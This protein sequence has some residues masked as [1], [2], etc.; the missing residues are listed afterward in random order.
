MPPALAQV[1]SAVP[2]E[3]QT[4][5]PSDSLPNPIGD[6]AAALREEA[7]SGV[8]NGKYTPEEKNGS[9]VVK[10][11]KVNNKDKYVELEKEGVDRIFVV[12]AEFGN[13]RH[14]DYLDQDTDAPAPIPRRARSRSTARCD[15]QIPEPDRSGGQLHG[16]ARGLQPGVLPGPV[17]RRRRVAEELLRDA[18]LGPLQ[19]RRQRSPT[20]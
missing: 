5:I 9:T 19:R 18:V 8:L 20:G 16:L 10:V 13:E 15:N 1:A 14:P 17:L 3:P 6:K 4:A 2:S 12:L 11:G 7:I